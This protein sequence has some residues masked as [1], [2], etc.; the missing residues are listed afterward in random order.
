MWIVAPCILILKMEYQNHISH[1]CPSKYRILHI[2][3]QIYCRSGLIKLPPR[4]ARTTKCRNRCWWQI[5]S[6]RQGKVPQLWKVSLCGMEVE[7]TSYTYTLHLGMFYISFNIC[8]CNNTQHDDWRLR[9]NLWF[10]IVNSK[11]YQSTNSILDQSECIIPQ[12]N[13]IFFQICLL[14][15]SWCVPS[16]KFYLYKFRGFLCGGHSHCDAVHSCRQCWCYM[17]PPSWGQ[18]SALVI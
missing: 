16:Q 18:G 17:L 8:C 1:S 15:Y 2:E 7:N 10:K 13:D 14:T 6:V 9:L 4:A 3:Q 5:S 11:P 12:Q